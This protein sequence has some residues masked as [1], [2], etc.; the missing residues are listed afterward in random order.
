MIRHKNFAWR[1]NH[2]RRLP[3]ASSVSNYL[4]VH[5][6][7]DLIAGVQG[8]PD[9]LVINTRDT[10]ILFTHGHQNDAL[11]QRRR[12]LTDLGVWLGGWIRR[13]GLG[14]AVSAAQ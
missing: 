7:H 4:Y 8:T 13:L 1:A 3:G 14:R 2:T 9:E 6:N 5:G 12:W 10:R 11:V